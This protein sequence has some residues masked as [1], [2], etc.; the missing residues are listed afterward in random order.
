MKEVYYEIARHRARGE[1]LC[2]EYCQ[3]W[4]DSFTPEERI[5]AI[6]IGNELLKEEK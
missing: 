3:L 6:Q 1:K 4:W 2:R 5:T